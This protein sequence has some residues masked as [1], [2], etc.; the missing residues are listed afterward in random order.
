MVG[1]PEDLSGVDLR[2]RRKARM[3]SISDEALMEL[4]VYTAMLYRTFG[5]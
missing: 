3:R 1:I 2:A 4:E 5:G